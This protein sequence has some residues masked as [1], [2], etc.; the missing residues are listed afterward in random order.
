[1]CHEKYLAL[2]ADSGL[3]LAHAVSDLHSSRE[4][5]T[6][7][8]ILVASLGF[9]V[10]FPGGAY[11]WA[12]WGVPMTRQT[13]AVVLLLFASILFA[14]CSG[15]PGGGCVSN[16][17][18]GNATLSFVLTATPPAPTLGLSVQTF[19]ATVTGISLTPSTGAAV[20]VPLNTSAYIA[21]LNRVTSE[22]TLLAAAVSVPAGT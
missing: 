6:L 2:V 8:S 11:S 21:E 7:D 1:M 22:S 19:A 18:G 14:S 9:A 20:N 16:C 3:A 12:M 15:A 4:W 10:R 13:S 17:G 5:P